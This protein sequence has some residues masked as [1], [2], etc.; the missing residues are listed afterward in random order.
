[1]GQPIQLSD[2]GELADAVDVPDS[3]PDLGGIAIRF[4]TGRDV[5]YPTFERA[6]GK[7]KCA[8]G[9]FPVDTLGF[10]ST[11][12]AA[13]SGQG[14]L[15]IGSVS[16]PPLHEYQFV[17]AGLPDPPNRDRLLLTFWILAGASLWA[18]AFV[19]VLFSLG[20]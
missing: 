11:Q 10:S 12:S 19:V 14:K 16:Q 5:F 13:K 1:M 8:K 15:K 3:A 18:L 9:Q 6:L 4:T 2:D 17:Q 20:H 7:D